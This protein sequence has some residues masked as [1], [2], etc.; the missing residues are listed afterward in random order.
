LESKVASFPRSRIGLG[1]LLAGK[2]CQLERA[3]LGALV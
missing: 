1:S 3:A 2:L